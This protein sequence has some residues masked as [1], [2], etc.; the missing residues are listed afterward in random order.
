MTMEQLNTLITAG[1]SVKLSAG[2]GGYCYHAVIT[3]GKLKI[4]G[5]GTT[6]QKSLVDACNKLERK[7][8]GYE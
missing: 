5:I 4:T 2:S 6:L 8:N 1:Y 7:R 3:S